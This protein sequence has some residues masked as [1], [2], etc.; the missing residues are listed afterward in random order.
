MRIL[1][2]LLNFAVAFAAC[3]IVC[4]ASASER[5]EIIFWGQSFGPDSK[6]FEATIVEFE[7]KNPEYK[8]RVLS[9]GAGRMNPQKL[10]TAIVGNVPPDVIYQDRFTLSDW[11][12]RG[13]FMPLDDLIARDKGKDP[14]TPDLSKYVP[15]TVDEAKF[16]GKLYGI[17]FG[18]DTR[19]LYYNKKIFRDEAENLRKAGLDPERPPRT[20]SEVLA[21]S[22]VLTKVSKDGRLLRAGFLPNYGNSWLYL[23]AF[24]NNASFI[25]PDGRRCTMN[26]PEARE[27]LKFM[28]DGY[29]LIGGYE[30][31]Q[32]FQAG[33][34]GNEND[35]FY[36]G[37]VAMK[38][39][40]DWILPNFL[41]FAP[42]LDFGVSEPP[43]PD[44]RYNKVGRFKDEKDQFI[45][46]AGGFSWA[47][48]R[49]ARNVEGGWKLLKWLGSADA[50]VMEFQAQADWE[51]R[52][53][54]EFVPRILANTEAN[55]RSYK[56]LKPVNANVAAALRMHIDVSNVARIRPVTFVGQT[57][58]NEHVRAVDQ[59]SLKVVS[60]E[61]AL[62]ES[63]DRVQKDL[64]AE[65]NKEKYPV[66]SM[67]IPA[68]LGGSV[69]VA[70]VVG[71][72]IYF[73][74]QK[75][76]RVGKNEAKWAYIMISPWLIGFLVFTVGPMVASLFFSFTQYNVL[77]EARWVGFK[78]YID[79]VQIDGERLTKAF[80]N[81]LYL[82]G[83]GLPLGIITGIA[84]AMLLNTGVKGMRFYRTAFYLP[85]IVPAIAGTI[86]W[87]F[88]LS[89]DPARGIVNGLWLSVITPMFGVAPPGWTSVE[90]WAKPAL[91]FMGL[92]GAGSGML[93]W[94]AALN[95]IPKSLYEAA[96]I[97]GANAKQQF[98]RITLPMLSPMILFSVVMGTIGSINEFDRVYLI[99]NGDGYGPNDTMLVP[100]YYLF[101]NAFAFFK[102]GYASA[103]A[104]VIFLVVMIIALLQLKL[105]KKFVYSEVDK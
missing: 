38:I 60:I 72:A 22:K 87:I 66:I 13:A 20:W 91:T 104:W 34:R 51:K 73:S 6:G 64:D 24:Q 56:L 93:L 10:M 80:S 101:Q 63:Q 33:F 23:Y 17:P 31:A 97:D 105:S 57:L 16:N 1:R 5:K 49:G 81:V 44:D 48:P 36:S 9:M 45:T 100:V 83:V 21:Y 82:G 92:W 95:G 50:R 62:Q 67:A 70:L 96:S 37:Q 89:P 12:N 99:T 74:R 8:V 75:L 77:T 29:D 7:K 55:E 11:A 3:M 78:N 103:L 76:G 26:T 61:K 65:W 86:L 79:L 39:D 102:M 94:L 69:A 85:A 84:V 54:R 58:W 43:V 27:A 59:A 52:R 2:A 40:G 68:M 46:W 30:K 42:S 88:I 32:T 4:N 15:A 90:S 14:L 98:F 28:V 18:C 47:I 41:R 53:G 35:P 71:F 19:V 25:S